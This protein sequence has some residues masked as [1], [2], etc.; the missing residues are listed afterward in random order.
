L[1]L[2]LAA[3]LLARLAMNESKIDALITGMHQIAENANILGRVVKCTKLTDDVL[4]QQV[5]VPLG[6]LLVIFESRPDSLPQVR[7]KS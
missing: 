1:C 2:D 7:T 6:V 5:T 3:P 4:L